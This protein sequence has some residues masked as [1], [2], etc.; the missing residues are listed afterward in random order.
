[1]QAIAKLVRVIRDALASDGLN[2]PLESLAAG[3]AGFAR[4]QTIGWNRAP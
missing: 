2:A 3:Y 4:K 1:M